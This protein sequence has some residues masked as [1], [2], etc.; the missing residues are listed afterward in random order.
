MKISVLASEYVTE[1]P[2]L[3]LDAVAATAVC[4]A[5]ARFYA[6][7]GD[8]A[9]VS[10]SDVLLSAAGA[11]AERPE[12]GDEYEN[13]LQALPIKDLGLITE[14]TDLSTGEWAIIRPL[15]ALYIERE[16]AMLLEA[17]RGLGA[18]PFGRS[19]A[20]VT[21]DILQQENEIIPAKGFVYTVI[22]V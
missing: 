5:A 9:S 16:N 11:S 4:V 13:V 3:V 18:D 22:E 6:G 1:R 21:Q 2:A 12:Y 19:V 14:D 17:T 15:F 20:E 8:I 7:Y 10:K